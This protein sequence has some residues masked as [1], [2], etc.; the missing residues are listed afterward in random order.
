MNW[1]SR[2]IN[3]LFVFVYQPWLDVIEINSVI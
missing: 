1:D 2:I 3:Q